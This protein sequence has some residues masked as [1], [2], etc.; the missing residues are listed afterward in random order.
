MAIFVGKRGPLLPSWAY[1]SWSPS[2]LLPAWNDRNPPYTTASI[3]TS[4]ME[5]RST[6]TL[7]HCR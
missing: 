1:G 5:L 3:S 6:S 2:L 7:R 4:Q